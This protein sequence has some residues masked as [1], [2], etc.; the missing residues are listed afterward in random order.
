M[1]I[2]TIGE[3]DGPRCRMSCTI[4]TTTNHR[5]SSTRRRRP[6]GDSAGQY[7]ACHGLVDD[8]GRHGLV[9]HEVASR[10]E[11]QPQRGEVVGAHGAVPGHRL[12][13]LAV[14]GRTALDF[15]AGVVVSGK[16][17]NRCQRRRTDPWHAPECVVQTVVEGDDAGGLSVADRWQRDLGCEQPARLEPEID[18]H[19]AQKASAEKACR[20]QQHERRGQLRHDERTAGKRGPSARTACTVAQG[21]GLIR[22]SPLD[23]RYQAADQRRHARDAESEQERHPVDRHLRRQQVALRYEGEQ[24]GEG[25]LRHQQSEHTAQRR[26]ESALDQQL[27]HDAR[28]AGTDSGAHCHLAPAAGSARQ[29][30]VGDIRARDQQHAA[31]GSEQHK[32]HEPDAGRLPLLQPDDRDAGLCVRVGVAQFER[33][34]EHVHA[35]L[36]LL[37]RDTVSQSRH[38]A[39]H[40]GAARRR[41]HVQ[42]DR[43]PQLRR[44]DDRWN[45]PG[46][47][48]A[49]DGV[50]LVAE[51]DDAPDDGGV[52][53][54]ALPPDD[55]GENDDACCAGPIVVR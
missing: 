35:C 38:H 37:A 51:H 40:D 29:Q 12:L 11:A 9:R 43:P 5:F 4:P 32:Q 55:V 8:H 48:H 45:E 10:H 30:Q 3:A 23:G 36:R 26:H 7:P 21:G 14:L 28:A 52:R 49:D 13:A 25:P 17:Q 50:R 19:Q 31:D 15:E 46:R 16:R 39:Q 1:N 34:R 41:H 44:P 18:R 47:H 2:S 24:G 6:T 54:K 20:H 42:P 22:T 53:R 33:A 27:T